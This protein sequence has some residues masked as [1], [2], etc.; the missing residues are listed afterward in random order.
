MTELEFLPY[1]P[2]LPYLPY[3]ESG[4]R[5]ASFAIFAMFDMFDR[6]GGFPV[7][8]LTEFIAAVNNRIPRRNAAKRAPTLAA[9]EP[10]GSAHGPT[11]QRSL[12]KYRRFPELRSLLPLHAGD[13]FPANPRKN[14][15][16]KSAATLYARANLPE[17]RMNLRTVSVSTRSTRAFRNCAACPVQ[18][19]RSVL[20]RCGTWSDGRL[21]CPRQ[22]CP[23]EMQIA[24]NSVA[25]RGRGHTFDYTGIS[26]G[27]VGKVDN[28]PT[29]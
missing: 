7:P 24:D 5:I 28:I 19:S 4:R 9:R 1:L 12:G 13:P 6:F 10:A 18:A 23:P 21:L 22:L 2:S 27:V 16:K 25:I 20:F 26:R 3:L 29:S 8:V 11:H 15:V 14:R 17:L